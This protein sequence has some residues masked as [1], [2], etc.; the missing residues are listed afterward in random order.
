MS[1]PTTTRQANSTARIRDDR[2]NASMTGQPPR[3]ALRPA[4]AVL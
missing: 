4:G 3:I 2:F 1:S